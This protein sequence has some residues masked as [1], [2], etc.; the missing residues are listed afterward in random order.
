MLA[1]ALAEAEEAVIDVVDLILG[2]A[3]HEQVLQRLQ[4]AGVQNA[5]QLVAGAPHDVGSFAGGGGCH[6]LTGHGVPL[7][8]LDNDL[9]AGILRLKAVDHFLQSD[10]TAIAGVGGVQEGPH[11]DGDVFAVGVSGNGDVFGFIG[12]SGGLVG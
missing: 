9:H 8:R 11:P 3:A 4:Q 2:P 7:L 1:V 10:G 12:R 6:E 5:K